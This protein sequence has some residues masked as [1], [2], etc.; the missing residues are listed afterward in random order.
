MKRWGANVI[1]ARNSILSTS[2]IDAGAP[3]ALAWLL[4]S[5]ASLSSAAGSVGLIPLDS[6][7]AVAVAQ[8]NVC[9]QA[10]PKGDTTC[11]VRGYQHAK[12]E[13]IV[14]L[15]RRPPAG[16]DRVV[17]RLLGNGSRVLVEEA[18]STKVPT[19]R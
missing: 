18:D 3:F 1:H 5:C 15:D 10:M 7:G 11:V 8:R 9:G 2:R 4:A 12:G 13:Y 6:A 17:V 16:N 14:T 19:V